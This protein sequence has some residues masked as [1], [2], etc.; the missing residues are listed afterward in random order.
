MKT[1]CEHCIFKVME[2]GIQTGCH[3]N[4]LDLFQKEFDGT[5][6][7]LE[8]YCLTCRNEYWPNAKDENTEK[9]L[10]AQSPLKYELAVNVYSHTKLKRVKYIVR[11]IEELERQPDRI[12]F[13]KKMDNRWSA[14]QIT[15]E[16][17]SYIIERGGIFNMQYG[18]G[19]PSKRLRTMFLNSSKPFYAY[20]N[21]TVSTK[22]FV[23]TLN[24]INRNLMVKQEAPHFVATEDRQF[25]F[26]SK[27]HYEQYGFYN[28]E[29]SN[30][31]NS[32]S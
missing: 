22:I 26:V 4:K 17:D 29:Q 6:Y 20:I 3:F 24:E 10:L 16:I 13:T 2:G 18:P 11:K 1:A 30:G 28:N 7:T 27:Q 19:T 8:G 32:E 25:I 12:I 15:E 23:D 5:H 9:A 14:N 31:S 21:N